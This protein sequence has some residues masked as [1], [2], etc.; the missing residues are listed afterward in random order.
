[1]RTQQPWF[2]L[3][4]FFLQVILN[5]WA[6]ILSSCCLLF[7]VCCAPLLK[8]ICNGSGWLVRPAPSTL[9][10]H[11]LRCH[12]CQR[13]NI[14]LEWFPFMAEN[15]CSKAPKPQVGFQTFRCQFYCSVN[16]LKNLIKWLHSWNL[17]SCWKDSGTDSKLN[18]SFRS[19]GFKSPTATSV[20]HFITLHFP[21]QKKKKKT[22]H[23][24][25]PIQKFSVSEELTSLS[26]QVCIPSCLS[27][28]EIHSSLSG[29]LISAKEA[30]LETWNGGQRIS[31]SLSRRTIQLTSASINQ[32]LSKSESMPAFQP[33][34]I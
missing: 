26:P 6:S 34:S 23:I 25:T 16:H 9:N 32:N 29:I 15:G 4:L 19:G 10:S 17:D 24:S 30:N 27:S 3:I 12:T 8:S 7:A 20:P 21:E 22:F 18:H 28:V 2:H 5:I 14:Y 11:K 31:I 1:M 13:S 33:C